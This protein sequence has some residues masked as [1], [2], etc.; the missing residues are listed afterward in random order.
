MS[1]TLLLFLLSAPLLAAQDSSAVAGSV[2]N[3]ITHAGVPGATV[4]ITAAELHRVLLTDDGSTMR[5]YP[6][7]EPLAQAVCDASGQFRITGLRPGQYIASVTARGFL[8]VSGR[9][10]RVSA[11]GGTVALDVALV[12]MASLRGRVLD[13]QGQTVPRV[14]VEISYSR[15]GHRQ[16][17][18]ST[19]DQE[20]RFEFTSL[21]PGTYLLMARPVL[22]GSY[23]AQGHPERL[24]Q[25]P[26]SSGDER[27]AW[28][29]VWYPGVSERGQAAPILIRAG[30]DS[31]G[32]EICLRRQPVFRVR[33]EVLDDAG[34][35]VPGVSIGLSPTDNWYAQEAQAVSGKNGAFEFPAV[36]PGSWR[37]GAESKQGGIDLKGFASVRITK[38]DLEDVGIRL[39]APFALSG[40]V[41]RDQ[42]RDAQGRPMLTGVSLEPYDGNGYWAMSL[43]GPD[44]Q[45]LSL[46]NVYPGRYT[47][48]TTGFIPGY[49]VDSIRLGDQEVIGKPVDLTAGSPP[50]R[51]VYKSDAGRVRG[52]VENGAGST[53]LLVPRD[54]AF[55]SPHFTRS[56]NCDGAGRFEIGSLRPG[57]YYA[58]AFDSIDSDTLRDA[59][60]DTVSF[61]HSLAV[62]AA[63]VRV[64]AGQVAQVDLRLT[65]WPE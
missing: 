52:T 26:Q 25:L 5:L 2:T 35:R 33:G 29:P 60:D 49:Y 22:A 13:D 53:V 48:T 23:L 11:A 40:V 38:E 61:V 18:D 55:M 30:V 62:R 50:I 43:H 44:G 65:P 28:V 3:S 12:P 64:E 63:T 16:T 4:T 46:S 57:E 51:V 32:Y 31:S 45:L 58:F 14:R 10:S 41:E 59:L 17:T 15:Y 20:G 39:S 56:G 24:S 6:G 21:A 37:L 36:R 54:E 1:K 47:I 8:P 9:A 19:T 34:E 7:R 42:Y 27:T